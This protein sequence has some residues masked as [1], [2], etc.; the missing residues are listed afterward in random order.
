MRR[1]GALAHAIRQS[2]MT[3]ARPTE[4]QAFLALVAVGQFFLFSTFLELSGLGSS[5]GKEFCTGPFELKYRVT[6]DSG[7]T[8]VVGYGELQ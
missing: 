1:T 4:E 7:K 3:L 5:Y 2:A 8:Y 6:L